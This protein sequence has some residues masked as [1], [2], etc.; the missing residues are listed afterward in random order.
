MHVPSQS[1]DT[2]PYYSLR[3]ILID[4]ILHVS[5]RFL[6]IDTFILNMGRREHII[7][8]FVTLGITPILMFISFRMFQTGQMADAHH[9]RLLPHSPLRCLLVAMV[10]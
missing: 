8:L 6:S 1:F 4:E 7:T 10:L 3:S 9:Q 2:T 5:K